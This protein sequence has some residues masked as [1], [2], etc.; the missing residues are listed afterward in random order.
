M[1]STAVF[2]I[3]LRRLI[4]EI[5]ERIRRMSIIE[6]STP[7]QVRM[8]N[9]AMVG[10]HSIN[11]VSRIHTELVKTSLAPD[12]FQLWPERFNNKTNGITQRRWLSEGESR[13]G[14]PDQLDHRRR[15][16]HRS[17][18][19]CGTRKLGGRCGLSGGVPQ[20]QAIEQ[21]ETG[22]DHPRNLAG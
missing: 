1:K 13:L 10:S 7:K 16:D 3:G 20:G 11:G 15:L 14:G 18:T 4:P 22:Q 8:A 12:F 5:D 19:G 2:W 6:E 9:L 21:G 17:L